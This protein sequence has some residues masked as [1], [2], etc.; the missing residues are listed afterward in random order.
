VE[1][2]EFL[3][4]LAHQAPRFP[5]VIGHRLLAG[6]E[7]LLDALDSRL[8]S[9]AQVLETAVYG[10]RC[11]A[12]AGGLGE[13]AVDSRGR[14]TGLRQEHQEHRDDCRGGRKHDQRQADEDGARSHEY[15]IRGGLDK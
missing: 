10:L 6:G 14:L 9:P 2:A 11:L 8:H 1:A 3:A 15:R 12:S 13:Q 4:E 5:E 7:A